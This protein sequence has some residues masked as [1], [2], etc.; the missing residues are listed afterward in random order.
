DV[1]GA[2]IAV[3]RPQAVSLHANRPDGSPRNSWRAAVIDVDHRGDRVRVRLEGPIQL[4]SEITAAAAAAL[5]IK[6]GLELW[7]AVK[8]T[9][10]VVTLN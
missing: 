1:D 2:A 7:A 10:I 4:T 6:V 9:E 5:G 8:A 3:I